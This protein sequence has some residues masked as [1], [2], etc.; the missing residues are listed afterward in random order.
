MLT[1]I[2][3]ASENNVIG[4]NNALLWH[5]PTDFKRFK[6]ITTGHPILMGRKTFDSLPGILPNRPH[7]IISRKKDL[8]LEKCTVVS[9]LDDAIVVA[10]KNHKQ[11][12]IIGGGEI[13]KQALK[14]ADKIEITRVHTNI[15]GDTFFPKIDTS[16][17]SL[18]FEEF[19]KKDDKHKYDYS[20]LTYNRKN[21][22]TS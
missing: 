18:T 21:N 10:Q 20:F 12:Y 14:I 9:S 8:F 2:V 1:I 19:H 3:A 4:K 11:L 13:Y 15:D 6:K 17:W 7:V 5:L 22:I 16:S